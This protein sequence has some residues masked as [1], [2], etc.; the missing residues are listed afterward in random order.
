[1]LF[2]MRLLG[3][4]NHL[5]KRSIHMP[6]LMINAAWVLVVAFV[7][8]IAYEFYR[9][10]IKAGVSKHDTLR[11]FITQLLT[12]Y[13]I[14]GIVIAL[15]FTGQMWAAWV[16]LVFCVLMILISIFYYNPVIQMEWS[17]IFLIGSKIWYSP[18]CFLSQRL[19]LLM[20]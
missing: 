8:S 1:M 13:L 15:L 20:L 11:G 19:N 5:N 18:G 2:A 16:G 12:L 4:R 9:S 14:A 17:L 10:T 6:V 7:L 3:N